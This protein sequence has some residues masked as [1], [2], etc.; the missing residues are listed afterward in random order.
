M[1]KNLFSVKYP[2]YQSTGHEVCGSQG[3]DGEQGTPAPSAWPW[4]GTAG[5]PHGVRSSLGFS[6]S[7]RSSSKPHACG[8]GDGGLRGSPSPGPTVPPKDTQPLPQPEHHRGLSSCPTGA[9]LFQ[10]RHLQP[11]GTSWPRVPC[12]GHPPHSQPRKHTGVHGPSPQPA[13]LRQEGFLLDPVP[14]PVRER[15]PRPLL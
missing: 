10:T 7:P 14:L 3:A 15:S 8:R 13:W 5:L 2:G 6:P 4:T 1:E 9:P 11:M 12:W